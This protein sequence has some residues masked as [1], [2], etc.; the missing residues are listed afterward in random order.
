M[1]QAFAVAL[2]MNNYFHDVATALLIATA[3]VMFIMVHELER[4]PTPGAAD[5]VARAYRSMS[6][7]ALGALVWIVI[8]GIP[9]TIFFSRFEWWDAAGKGIIPALVVKHVLIFTLVVIGAVWWRRLSAR[10]SDLGAP[11]SRAPQEPKD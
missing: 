9:R 4:D 8:G 1:N 10:V 11:G 7:L 6:R 2:M 5:F 3:A